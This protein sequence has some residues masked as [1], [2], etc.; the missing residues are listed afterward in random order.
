MPSAPVVT[1]VT[2]PA[3]TVASALLAFHTPPVAVSVNV[4]LVPMHSAVIPVM[5]LILPASGAGLMVM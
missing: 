2:K 3:D 5:L 1:A 4:T